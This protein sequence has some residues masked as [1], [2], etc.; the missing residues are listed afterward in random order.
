MEPG[1]T[2]EDAVRVRSARKPA[3]AAG[4][5]VTS[6]PTLAV[7]FDLDDGFLADAL[8]RGNYGRP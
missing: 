7:S 2:L 3:S 6:L 5:S 4:E 8:N 1:E